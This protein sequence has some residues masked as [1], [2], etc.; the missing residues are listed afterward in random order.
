MSIHSNRIEQWATVVVSAALIAT[1]SVGGIAGNAMSDVAGATPTVSLEPTSVVPADAPNGLAAE[2]ETAAAAEVARVAAE[3]EAARV[4]AEAEAA[5]VA[6][7][8][9]AARIAAEQAAAAAEAEVFEP[10]PAPA[11][12][13]VIPPAGGPDPGAVPHT[14]CEVI[15]G[16]EIPC[17]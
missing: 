5:R 4:A 2:Q 14:I 1:V 11:P 15:D 8:A 7:E 12:E 17:Q 6:A 3:A 13:P 9:E 16:V 10:E